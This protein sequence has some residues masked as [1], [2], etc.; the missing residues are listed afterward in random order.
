MKRASMF[1][2]KTVFLAAILTMVPLQ[3]LL[4]TA[5]AVNVD[6]FVNT[7]VVSSDNFT[8]V[9][10]GLGVIENL[11]TL[12]SGLDLNWSQGG[13]SYTVRG[14]A[15][16]E[17]LDSRYDRRNLVYRL[18]TDLQFF[19]RSNHY[20]NVTANASSDT[21][22]PQEDLLDSNR[23][24]E[25]ILTVSVATGQRRTTSSW[26]IGLTKENVDSESTQSESVRLNARKI[27]K[28]GPREEFQL[29][30]FALRGDDQ[31]TNN[32]WREGEFS[33]ELT[34][35]LSRRTVRGVNLSWS[36]SKTEANVSSTPSRIDNLSLRLFRRSEISAVSGV[37]ASL[38]VNGLKTEG[39]EREWSGQAELTFNSQL[40]RRLNFNLD[41]SASNRV[42]RNTDR[43]PEWS[44]TTQV[45]MEL[46]YSILRLWGAFATASYRED[47][48][49][50]GTAG[51]NP[52]LKRRDENF[53]SQWGF[54]GQPSRNSEFSASVIN[55]E[56]KSNLPT[57]VFEE[58]RLE[59]AASIM[60]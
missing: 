28:P 56:V 19:R 51:M 57:A 10:N 27:W 47:N 20:V 23:V 2:I 17:Y 53:I 25:D 36:E 22:T 1:I 30:G 60:F 11:Y 49:P 38:G 6:W 39:E 13:S 44:R 7:R 37:G 15:G 43:S 12:T 46:D 52:G 8:R 34:E 50:Q 26:E 14:E 4:G 58:N 16:R 21:M 9:P 41:S 42:L 59:F 54:R 45:S 33:A 3:G 31:E 55:E 40:A 29:S 32:I 18:N 5:Q 48:F 35:T 24:Q